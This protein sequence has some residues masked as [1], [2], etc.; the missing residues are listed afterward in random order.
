MRP[1][2][3]TGVNA[4]LCT[5]GMKSEEKIKLKKSP[6]NQI[7]ARSC[8]RPNK[9][10]HCAQDGWGKGQRGNARSLGATR[11]EKQRTTGQRLALNNK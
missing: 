8:A 3:E 4:V 5:E 11:R 2:D 6:R 1:Q 9:S 10:A 7:Q